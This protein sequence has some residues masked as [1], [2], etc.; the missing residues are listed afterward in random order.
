MSSSEEEAEENDD[1]FEMEPMPPP[2]RGRSGAG[3]GGPPLR[4]RGQPAFDPSK[5]RGS[6]IVLGGKQSS[7]SVAAEV[8]AT[9]KRMHAASESN[10]I[11]QMQAALNAAGSVA[12]MAGPGDPTTVELQTM[13]MKLS[14]VCIPLAV[15]VRLQLHFFALDNSPPERQI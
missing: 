1:V 3:G 13:A 5:R 14:F 15:K 10:D 9:V 12:A 11:N 8:A 4:E 7:V 2:P 6:V